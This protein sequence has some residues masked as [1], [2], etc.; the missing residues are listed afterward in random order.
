MTKTESTMKAIE[1]LDYKIMRVKQHEK[2]VFFDMVLN[3][4]YIYGLSVVEGKNGDFISWPSRKG[5]DNKYY[6]YAF[7]KFSNAQQKDI[8]DAVQTELD[9]T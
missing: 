7:A 8:L 2:T 9:K 6:S 1:N 5:K 4:V 3:G